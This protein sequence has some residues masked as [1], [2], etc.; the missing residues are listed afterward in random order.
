MQLSLKTANV[1]AIDNH[2]ERYVFI[3]DETPES[4]SKLMRL[5]GL[6]AGCPDLKFNWYD[7]AAASKKALEL[8]R[9]TNVRNRLSG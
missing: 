7:A 6:Y 1:V 9:R 8:Q 2:G 4:Q 5:L 3:Y